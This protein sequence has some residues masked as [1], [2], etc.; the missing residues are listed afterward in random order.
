[1]IIHSCP[2]CNNESSKIHLIARDDDAFE[3]NGIQQHK[4][5]FKI[6]RC[7]S[8]NFVYVKDTFDHSLLNHQDSMDTKKIKIPNPRRR[9]WLV[10]GFLEKIKDKNPKILEIGCG[11]GELVNLCTKN[12]FNYTAIEPS[13]HRSSVLQKEGLP[14]IT[15]TVEE[16][17]ETSSDKY[18][19]VI[20]DN[21]LEHVPEPKKIIDSLKGLMNKDAILII[22]VPNLKDY[23]AFLIP[24]WAKK[25]WQPIAH[26]NYFTYGTLKKLLKDSG[27]TMKSPVFSVNKASRKTKIINVMQ[28]VLSKIGIRPFGLYAFSRLK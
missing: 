5:D 26:V 9:H 24:G 2:V 21:V 16:H 14:V 27:F 18:D 10:Y 28:L 25:Q 1:M 12:G 6:V 22:I 3:R 13:Q 4:R 20:M 23:R 8:C 15:E 17:L 11:F 7:T 19:V